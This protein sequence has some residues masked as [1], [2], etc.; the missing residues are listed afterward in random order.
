MRFFYAKNSTTKIGNYKITKVVKINSADE[1]FLTEARELIY[2]YEERGLSFKTSRLFQFYNAEDYGYAEYV[3]NRQ[4]GLQDNAQRS[5]ERNGRGIVGETS[6]AS[7]DPALDEKTTA[8][9]Q[10]I[11]SDKKRSV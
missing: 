7:I 11:V 4:G 10:T 9:V 3:R 5:G 6:R 8:R 1:T 2:D